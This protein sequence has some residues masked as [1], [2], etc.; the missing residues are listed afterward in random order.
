[1][2]TQASNTHARELRHFS[3][4]SM[5]DIITGY[6]S[7]TVVW[8]LSTPHRG[9]MS[10]VSNF[11]YSITTKPLPTCTR[12]VYYTPWI[13]RNTEDVAS[14][15]EKL[16]YPKAVADQNASVV[17]GCYAACTMHYVNLPAW[18][19]RAQLAHRCQ[20][21]WRIK[22]AAGRLSHPSECEIVT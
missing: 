22:L 13:I 6:K 2:H 7:T 3:S 14:S 5:N 16:S 1:M 19:Q 9:T 15:C 10:A 18:V 21:K 17:C 12:V 11:E 8:Q 20:S 4:H